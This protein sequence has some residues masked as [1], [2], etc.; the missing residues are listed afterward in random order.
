MSAIFGI[1]DPRGPDR[2]SLA[3]AAAVVKFRGRPVV[4]A[5]GPAILGTYAREGEEPS[6]LER[7]GV[8]I[9]AHARVDAVLSGPTGVDAGAPPAAVLDTVL[10]RSG[11][12]GLAGLAADFAVGRWDGGTD[13]LTLSRDAFGLRP[14]Y[15]ARRGGRMGF[16]SDP[17]VLVALGMA[18]GEL[19][20]GPVAAYLAFRDFGGE[21][22][23]FTG[24]RRVVGGRWVS[25]RSDGRAS[26]GGWFRPEEVREERLALEEAAEA[27]ADAVTAAAASRAGR[28]RPAVLLSG[29]RDSGAV[30]M[31]LRRAGV[32]ARCLTQTFDPA[33][34]CTEEGP[35]RELAEAVGHAWTPHPAPERV[36]RQHLELLPVVAGTPLAAPGFAQAIALREA[37]A[38]ARAS[39]VLD[40]LGGEPLFSAGPVAVLDL[41]R[42]GR[43]SAAAEAAGGFHHRWIYP[44][45]VLA[46]AAARAMAPRSL[47]ALR[48]R[49]RPVPPW[50]AEALSPGPD[51]LTAPRDSREHLLQSLHRWGAAPDAELMERLFATAGISYASPLLDQRVVRVA[52]GLPVELRVP[53]P[54]PKP[55]L[56]RALLDGF[57]STRTKARMTAYFSRLATNL[58]SDFP[59]MYGREGSVAGASSLVRADGLGAVHRPEWRLG[60]LHLASLGAWLRASPAGNKVA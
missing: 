25:F 18:S 52:L 35:A 24:I 31:A 38:A 58:L 50:V 27:V 42:W 23:A 2:Q 16:A 26:G 51:P 32:S 7:N 9:A 48:E 46:K 12:R 11:P 54:G 21:R 1:L 53:V 44:Y 45:P 49:L 60:A 36:T 29:G 57:E 37:A 17:E 5:S 13:T 20:P 22:T 28:E 3:S 15:W 33:L 40:G 19:D 43:L 34:G 59:E 14:L 4:R 41:L 10:E 6:L 56:S 55:V 30:A 39:V 8:L 47:L